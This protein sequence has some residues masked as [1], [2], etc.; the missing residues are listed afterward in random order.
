MWN[1]VQRIWKDGPW[2]QKMVCP[3]ECLVIIPDDITYSPAQLAVTSSLGVSYGGLL[4][5]NLRP[6]QNVIINGGTGQ[7]GSFAALIALALGMA[8]VR[9]SALIVLCANSAQRQSTRNVITWCA[10]RNCLSTIPG[11]IIV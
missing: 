10:C 7:L 6:G 2:A 1:T 8:K 5:C 4:K 9:I 3:A 11:Y